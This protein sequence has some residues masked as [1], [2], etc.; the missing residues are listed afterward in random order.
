MIYTKFR[1]L[2]ILLN[3]PIDTD[4]QD[5]KNLNF[6]VQYCI[7]SNNVGRRAETQIFLTKN[8]GNNKL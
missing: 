7:N 6:Y 3:K 4:R 5:K 1:N 2:Q 8:L